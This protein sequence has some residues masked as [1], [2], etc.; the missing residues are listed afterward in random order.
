M[1]R[2]LRWMRIAGIVLAIFVWLASGW[3]NFIEM[4]AGI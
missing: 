4:F 1:W 2:R 3:V